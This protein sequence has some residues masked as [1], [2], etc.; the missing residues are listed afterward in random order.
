M[1]RG[2][3][4]GAA[5]FEVES[6]WAEDAAFSSPTRVALLDKVDASGLT[7]EMIDPVRVTQYRGERALKIRGVMG[8]QFSIRV[9]LTGHGSTTSGATSATALGTLLGNVIGTVAV[10]AAS[11][12]TVDTPTDADSWT[13]AASGTFSAGSVGFLGALGDGD[14]NGQAFVVASHSGTSMEA[15]T[16]VDDTPAGSAVVYSAENVYPDPDGA[17]SVV[18]TRWRLF[19]ANQQY[20]CHGCFPV[21]ISYETALGQP[22]AATITFQVSW[23]EP[24]SDTFPVAES[25]N[26]FVPAPFAGGSFF[27]RAHGST[28]RD[29]F[30]I[31]SASI[32]HDLGIVPVMGPDGVNAYQTVVGAYRTHDSLMLDVTVEAQTAS[33]APT[34]PALWDAESYLHALLTFNGAASGKRLALYL[35]KAE[36][37]GPKPVQ[38]DEDGQ[39][40]FRLQL[41]AVTD[42][43]GSN[44]LTRAGY[45]WALG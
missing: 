12:T 21:S 5:L 2:S 32:T 34:I 23:W 6:A 25:V 7:Q 18:S 28:T 45:V 20:E 15:A 24:V 27:M 4:L 29:L 13:T 10:A 44:D 36:V 39:N 42:T 3:V 22:L 17:A 33:A 19:T 30:S 11:G 1:S 37:R 16:A 38:I 40:R 14:G 31:R 9:W 43:A 26:D 41:Q 35:R 8:G